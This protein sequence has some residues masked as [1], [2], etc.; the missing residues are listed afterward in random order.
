MKNIKTAKALSEIDEEYII[1]ALPE[2]RIKVTVFPWKYLALAS[3][4]ALIVCLG[5]MAVLFSSGVQSDK[6]KTTSSASSVDDTGYEK[7]IIKPSDSSHADIA[8]EKSWEEKNNSERFSEMG[9]LQKF[10][11]TNTLVPADRINFSPMYGVLN[12]YAEARATDPLT[13]KTYTIECIEYAIKGININ[14]AMAV[15]FKGEEVYY[16]YVNTEFIP[17]TFKEFAESLDLENNISFGSAYYTLNDGREIE[18]EGIDKKKVWDIL[19]SD[20]SSMTAL[21]DPNDILAKGGFTKRVSISTNMDVLGY[22][23]ITMSF[24]DDG[25]LFTNLLGTAKIFRIDAKNVQRLKTYLTSSCRGYELIYEGRQPSESE[26][27]NEQKGLSDS[28]SVS[29]LFDENDVSKKYTVF[30]KVSYNNESFNALT[31]HSAGST[32]SPQEIENSDSYGGAI[33]YT[34]EFYKKYRNTDKSYMEERLNNSIGGYS[35][36][37]KHVKSKCAY[38]IKYTNN[39]GVVID[40]NWYVFTAKDFS[41]STLYEYANDIGMKYYAMYTSKSQKPLAADKVWDVIFD[42]GEKNVIESDTSKYDDSKKLA[43]INVDIS[44]LGC[45]GKSIKVSEDGYLYADVFGTPKVFNIGREK[46]Q[47]IADYLNK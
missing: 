33:I 24:S 7:R 18:F 36:Q 46:A 11:S 1:E 38:A 31:Y 44:V 13:N 26:K 19:F 39:F 37:L 29:K 47:K 5:V 15:K 41:P 3:S 4:F 40:D 21:S 8:K 16:A 14:Y 34:E 9:G 32:I 17:H 45:K 30:E 28:S 6:S 27:A 2:E 10:V 23:N 43:E 22:K 20:T 42:D 35:A 25:M 12:P